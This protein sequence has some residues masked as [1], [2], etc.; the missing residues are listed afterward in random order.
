MAKAVVELLDDKDYD[1]NQGEV[2][3]SLINLK[4]SDFARQWPQDFDGVKL[5][6]QV[7][8]KDEE[9]KKYWGALKVTV[10][11]SEQKEPKK[12][13]GWKMVIIYKSGWVNSIDS[14]TKYEYL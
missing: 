12:R 6:V 11:Q 14:W 13:A 1:C 10:V 8:D 7:S 5:V 3:A 9:D 4:Q 2:I